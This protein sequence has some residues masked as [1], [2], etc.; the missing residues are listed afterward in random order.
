MA[1]MSEYSDAPTPK[2]RRTKYENTVEAYTHHS[3]EE[4]YCADALLLLT[5]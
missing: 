5:K 4:M 3:F 2:R 1:I